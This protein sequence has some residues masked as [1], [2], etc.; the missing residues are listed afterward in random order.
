MPFIQVHMYT[1]QKQGKPLLGG[2]F[3]VEI[4]TVYLLLLEMWPNR[5]IGQSCYGS[6]WAFSNLQ[7]SQFVLP[8]ERGVYFKISHLINT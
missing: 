5:E 6:Q 4:I 2:I 7:R 8:G 3:V 1:H